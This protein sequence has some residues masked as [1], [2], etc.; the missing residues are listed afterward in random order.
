MKRLALLALLFPVA[1]LAQ[2]QQPIPVEQQA[3]LVASQGIDAV[4]ALKN[5]VVQQEAKIT[6]LQLQLKELMEQ[7]N[8]QKSKSAPPPKKQ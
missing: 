2:T 3:A 6:E 4:E 8:Q 1:G 7:L 5:T